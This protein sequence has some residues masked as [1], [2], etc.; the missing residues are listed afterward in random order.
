MAAA[1]DQECDLCYHN[2]MGYT[3]CLKSARYVGEE[4]HHHRRMDGAWSA[5]QRNPVKINSKLHGIFVACLS[6]PYPPSYYISFLQATEALLIYLPACLYS[7]ASSCLPACIYIYRVMYAL[8]QS[9]EK[10]DDTG[11]IFLAKTPIESSISM[12]NNRLN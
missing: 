11:S 6:L 12:T 4:K 1:L 7:L 3:F 9:L 2:H 10:V 5:Y 8:P